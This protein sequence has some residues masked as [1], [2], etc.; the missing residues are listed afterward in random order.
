MPVEAI[1]FNSYL[2]CFGLCWNRDT[3]H[4]FLTLDQTRRNVE[5]VICESETWQVLCKC[6]IRFEGHDEDRE[7]Q[8]VDEDV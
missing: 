2:L 4:I 6:G 8:K 7:G 3:R 5:A 1:V